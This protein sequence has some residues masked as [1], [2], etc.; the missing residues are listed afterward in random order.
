MVQ[1]VQIP[2]TRTLSAQPLPLLSDVFPFFLTAACAR[3]PPGYPP[4]FLIALNP[5]PAGRSLSASVFLDKLC[6]KERAALHTQDIAA[7]TIN[8]PNFVY[9]NNDL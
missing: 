1:F 4:F 2:S 8:H 5:F 9:V 7:H 6:V 3:F